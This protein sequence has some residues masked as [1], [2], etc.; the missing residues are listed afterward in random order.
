MKKCPLCQADVIEY[1]SYCPACRHLLP[2][3]IDD[4][5]IGIIDT[6]NDKF[7]RNWAS[8]LLII[9]FIGGSGVLVRAIDWKA[10]NLLLQGET[11]TAEERIIEKQSVNERFARRKISRSRNEVQGSNT[12]ENQLAVRQDGSP[13]QSSTTTDLAVASSAAI[14]PG[15]VSVTRKSNQASWP[16]DQA[17]EIEQFE[18]PPTDRTGIVTIKSQAPA[19]VYIDGQYSGVTPR[20][21]NLNAGA[22]QVRLV[23]DGYLEWN[24]QIQVRSR[25]KTGVVASLS[26]NE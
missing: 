23:S 17:V 6:I 26:R 8:W 10:L 21:V 2:T 15:S 1:H 12:T 3:S 7:R 11:M 24:N 4:R 18:A 19:R 14:S 16:E 20:T 5:D 22:H 9:G 13:K 25:E